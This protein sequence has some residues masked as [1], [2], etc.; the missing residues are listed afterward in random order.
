MSFARRIWLLAP[1]LAFAACTSVVDIQNS[2][3]GAGGVGGASSS[4]GTGGS[5]PPAVH[6]GPPPPGE[7][8]APP[9]LTKHLAFAVNRFFL[10]DTDPD[11]TPD[12]M[13]GW[14]HLGYDVDGKISTASSTDLCQ[15]FFPTEPKYLHLDDGDDEIDNAFS[16]HLLP[17][18]LGM[19]A[20]FTKNIQTNVAAGRST[21][22]IAVDGIGAGADYAP[23]P[24]R[25]YAGAPL[26]HAA[27]F[28]GTDV[29]PVRP[30]AL[31]DPADV[32]KAVA[33]TDA[34]YLVGDT[35]VGRFQG[36]LDLEL[37]TSALGSIHLQITA[38]VVS[39]RLDPAHQTVKG[40]VIAG[41]CATSTISDTMKQALIY[42]DPNPAYWCTGSGNPNNILPQLEQA[43]DILHDGTQDPAQNCDGIS[44]GL[45]FEAV[46][47]VVGPVGEPEPPLPSPCGYDAGAP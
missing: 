18:F 34:S 8:A 42:V 21:L 7:A 39:M 13:N 14:R 10:G 17:I 44:V 46:P 40:G 5:T 32:G 28:D 30:Y 36:V 45:G 43:S 11:G 27:A 19:N 35:W 33:H 24:A 2:T 31:S 9:D 20:D 12:V 6:A 37:P 16:R 29:W 15:P 23:L 22:L 1:G 26:G 47:V 25:L 41:V 4:V 3:G 38:P